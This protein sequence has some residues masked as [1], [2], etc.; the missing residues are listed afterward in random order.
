[1]ETNT[2]TPQEQVKP[3]SG[4]DRLAILETPTT[5]ETPSQETNKPETPELKPLDEQE[6]PASTEETQAEP[7]KEPIFDDTE[8]TETQ[9]E[10]G[11]WKSL[12]EDLG[13]EVPQDYSEENGYDV[14][15]QLHESKIAQAK[16]QANN[17]S[18]NEY[19]SQFPQ[20]TQAEAMLTIELMKSGQTLEQI[21]APFQ[22]I[23]QWRQMTPEQL[24]RLN[25]SRTEGITEDLVDHKMEALKE[26]GK[27]DAEYKLL[28][29]DINNYEKRISLERQQQ[30]QYFTA[31]QNQIREQKRQEDLKTVQAALNRKST[32]MDIKLNDQ[33]KINLLK[34]YEKNFEQLMKN[35]EIKAEFLMWNR[36]GKKA[37]EYMQARALDNAT[38]LKMKEQLNIKPEIAGG[39]RTQQNKSL[40]GQDRLQDLP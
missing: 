12:M 15:K 18:I 23:K 6:N 33:N 1:M 29:V 24:V 28:M 20:E 37:V 7:A 9:P 30:I 36:Y 13:F 3:E 34:D 21:N 17:F 39:G 11:S 32:F 35:P 5:T 40:T 38:A 16:E 25:I 4:Q 8:V 31:Q 19:V 22:E 2:A 26:S 14:F 10:E 27:L